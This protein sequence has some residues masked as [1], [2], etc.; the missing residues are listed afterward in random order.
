MNANTPQEIGAA[1]RLLSAQD[2]ADYLGVPLATIYAWRHRS[3]GP[4]GLRVGRHLRYRRRDL[5]AWI[6]RQLAGQQ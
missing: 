1:D 4:P 5:D 3:Q 6:E 2:V